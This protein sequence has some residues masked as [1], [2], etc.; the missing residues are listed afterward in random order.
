MKPGM[1]CAR[2]YK[3]VP[4]LVAALLTF[5][6]ARAHAQQLLWQVDG[7]KLDYLGYR[8]AT[9]ADIDGDGIPDVI[10]GATGNNVARLFSGATGALIFEWT[11][12]PPSGVF[13]RAV[14]D[15]G[16]VNADG[17]DD[18]IVGA[19]DPQWDLG[20][21]FV[22]SGA[23]G[24]ELFHFTGTK[25][26]DH[27]GWSVCGAGDV[28]GDGHADVALGV[29]ADETRFNYNERV[30]LHSG[31]DG[32][33]LWT[34]FPTQM[35]DLFG[36]VVA[37][38][39]DLN[40]D[41]VSELVVSGVNHEHV[42][43]LNGKDGSQLLDI[44]NPAGTRDFFGFSGARVSDYDGDGLGDLLI[45]APGYTVAG[46]YGTGRAYV[47]SSVSGSTLMTFEGATSGAAL[48]ESVA[49]ASD[50]NGD[51]W[52]DLLIGATG[53]GAAELHSGRTGTLLYRFKSNP[54]QMLGT[55]VSGLGDV[56]GDGFGEVALGAPAVT[57]GGIGLDH[58]RVSVRRGGP[59]FLDSEPLDPAAG[60]SLTLSLA[61]GVPGSI[62]FIAVV[63]LNGAPMFQVVTIQPLN[64]SG[65]LQLS[66]TIPA[67]LGGTTIG[68]RGFSLAA[69]ARLIASAVETIAIQ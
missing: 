16:D 6:G 45:G 34:A 17:V 25:A 62:A 54:A 29:P 19:T 58:G 10:A 22:F 56:D 8:V 66:G 53:A 42:V 27:L 4:V 49:D 69:S 40:G 67:G 32:S 46:A 35:D 51:G 61:E 18:L 57:G 15:A 1:V 33:L 21:A 3:V 7:Q 39:D 11:H 63:A 9:T 13:G 12:T 30:E 64:A 26:A 14:A 48:G 47:M 37:R 28:D 24:S 23:D 43:V 36:F 41:G 55:S 5:E 52:N 65:V 2:V 44:P 31:A 20:D 60:T 59:I 68:L 50:A 38:V